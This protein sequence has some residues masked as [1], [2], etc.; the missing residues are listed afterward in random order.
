LKES[1]LSLYK[2]NNLKKAKWLYLRH[3][4]L[5]KHTYTHTHTHT[6]RTKTWCFQKW[7]SYISTQFFPGKVMWELITT[8]AD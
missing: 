8:L 2:I 3:I 6:H 1:S 4:T 7:A 5:H